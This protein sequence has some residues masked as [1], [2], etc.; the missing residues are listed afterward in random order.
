[1]DNEIQGQPQAMQR[2]GRALKTITQRLKGK[3]GRL[4]GNLM[5]KRVDFSARTVITG[6]P[7]ID[8]DQVGVPRSIARNLTYPEIVTPFNIENMYEL[9]RNGPDEHPGAKYIIRDDGTRLDLRY[10][11][12]PNDLRLEAGFKV[13][14][15]IQNDDIIVFNR[16]P[17]LHKMSM[18]GHRVKIMPYSTFRLNLS[19]TSPYNADFDGDEMNLHVPQTIESR[20]EVKEIMRV[21]KQ[22]VS[23][24][25]NEVLW[26]ML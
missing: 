26:N 8:I 17:S 18:M 9:I 6:D 10:V 7:I 1:M 2:S 3:E 24:Q 12:R 15:H 25:K 22:I 11:K 21:P 19:V 23:P 14:R 5:G 16:Q 20:M 13:E 4:R